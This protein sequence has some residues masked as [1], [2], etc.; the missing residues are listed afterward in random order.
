MT[1][2]LPPGPPDFPFEWEHESDAELSWEW[3]NMHGPN[4][5]A[6]MAADYM[7]VIG[8]GFGYRFERLD[9]P[10]QV[11]FRTWHG[12][13][14]T[15]A[16][17]HVPSG[18]E[19]AFGQRM[20]ERRRGVI[21]TTSDYWN[22]KAIPELRAAYA[23]IDAIQVEGA[24]PETLAAD[25]ERAWRLLERA[26]SIHFFVITGAYQVLDDLADRYEALVPGASAG[27][28]LRLVQGR[29]G[30]LQ[31]VGDALERLVDLARQD[32]IAGEALR[33][34]AYDDLP[35]DGPFHD[36]L[37][38]FLER[39]GHL[40]Q[41]WDDLQLASWS[42]DPTPLYSDLAKRLDQPGERAEDR[43]RRLQDDSDRLLEE[44]RARLASK[45]DELR[46]FESLL[47]HA[48]EIGHLTE[49]HNYWIDRMA[50]ATLRR[51]AMRVGRR[52]VGD[53]V[54]GAVEDVFYLH[55]SEIPELIRAP[56]GMTGT[57][58][59][60]KAEHERQRTMTPPPWIGQ[61]PEGGG[62][63]F[64][65]PERVEHQAQEVRGAGASP[66]IARGPARVALGQDDFD[67]IQPGDIIVCP[68]SNPSWVPLFSIAAGL[69]TDA[70]GVLSHAAV[71]AREFGLPA[72]VGTRDGTSRIPDGRLIEIDG[73]AG[74]VRIL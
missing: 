33:A 74:T 61:P 44:V 57:L 24:D 72:V 40:G 56:R 29:L 18:G 17:L 42:E 21:P 38:R 3:D 67:R 49:T 59:E 25:W 43:R 62:G 41:G 34:G 36:E 15:T 63:R 45:P 23:S 6:P 70:G 69:V 22:R 27:E 10:M 55:R 5:L 30:D 2:I 60:R 19:E 11:I 4:P 26:W 12:Y 64:D 32:P 8:Q 37:A 66:G 48:R 16:R 13:L 71:V 28:A 52:L 39:H 58:A 68:S 9:A 7:Q 20:L 65:T 73:S 35:T 47:G 1:P 51:L 50:Q 54:I 53:G 31:D 14:Y 46:D